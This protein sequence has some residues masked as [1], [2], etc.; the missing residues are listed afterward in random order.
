MPTPVVN[1]TIPVFNRLLLTQRTL[2]ALRKV[3]REIPFCVTVVDNGSAP[4]LRERLVEFHK[5]GII[6]HLFLLP[7]NMG[8]SCACN[9]GW[10]AVDAPYY[11]KLDNDVV[12]QRPDFLAH[13]FRLWAH[14]TPLSILGPAMLPERL[15]KNPGAIE[16]PDGVLGICTENVQGTAVLIPRAVS[17]AL[18]YW[19]EDYGLYGAD[20][21]DYGLRMNCAGFTQ[22]YYDDR[23]L[24]VHE[25]EWGNEEYAGTG[26][27]KG[28]EH[29]NLFNDKEGGVGLFVLNSY[30]YDMCIRNWNVPRRWRIK[31]ISGYDVTL[32][33]DP[34]YAPVREALRRSKRIFDGKVNAGKKM[35][36]FNAEVIAKMKR[37]WE[38]CG[39][40]CCCAAKTPGASAV[41]SE[42]EG[43]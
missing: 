7:R 5:L 43:M 2:L 33:E 17:D 14:G 4:E 11:M 42:A 40:G 22:Y 1:I 24:F 21:G 37:I 18:G 3:S 20:D 30:L 41:D 32:E 35:E 6:D 38:D 23:G 12:V 26:L 10:Q 8:I 16:T 29:R 27:D 39:Q 34:A 15:H 25:G 36:V 28:A 31:Y 13:L 19:N 9:I